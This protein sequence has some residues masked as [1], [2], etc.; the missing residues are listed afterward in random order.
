V[1]LILYYICV[2]HNSVFSGLR[3]DLNVVLEIIIDVIQAYS[4]LNRAE[5]FL[6]EDEVEVAATALLADPYK[7][8]EVGFSNATTG[9]KLTS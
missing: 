1:H 2:I 3:F 7:Q 8:V 9:W 4:G 5:K 6:D